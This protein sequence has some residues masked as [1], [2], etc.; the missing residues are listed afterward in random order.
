MKTGRDAPSRLPRF[1]ATGRP[2]AKLA[3]NA[4]STAPGH[5]LTDVIRR[6]DNVVPAGFPAFADAQ[7]KSAADHRRAKMSSAYSQIRRARESQ[8]HHRPGNF[9]QRALAS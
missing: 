3:Q 7:K 8:A 1:F 4:T 2:C 9:A 6:S 5:D